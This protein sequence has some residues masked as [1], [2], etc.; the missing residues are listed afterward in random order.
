[1]ANIITTLLGNVVEL[2]ET[3]VDVALQVDPLSTL[4]L[5][6]GAIFVLFAGGLFGYLAL[7]GLLSSLIP[8]GIGRTPPQ[9]GR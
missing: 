5:A 1:M 4:L 3:F 6:F 8:D 9:Q 7:G 2:V